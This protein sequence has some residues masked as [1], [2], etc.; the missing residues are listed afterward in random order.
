MPTGLTADIEKGISFNQFVL[1]CARAMGALI[2]MRDE[3]MDAPIPTEFKPSDYYAKAIKKANKELGRYKSM[4]LEKAAKA[5]ATQHNKDLK[6][7]EQSLKRKSSLQKKYEEMLA[8]VKKWTPP[9]KEH[10][11][12]KKFMIQQIETSIDYDCNYK[13]EKPKKISAKSWL[14]QRK[15]FA[16]RDLQYY[17]EEY[18]KE[19][20]RCKERTNWVQSLIKSL[21]NSNK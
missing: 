8:E 19:I 6:Y 2:S 5:S 7:Y 4:T 1:T 15:K 17:T 21:E 11:E 18:K 9:T 14:S 20:E 12:F 3:P 13:S 10:E 16:K